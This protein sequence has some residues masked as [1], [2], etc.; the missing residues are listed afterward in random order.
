MPGA[1][2]WSVEDEEPSF[3]LP[4]TRIFF[5]AATVKDEDSES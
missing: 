5:D 2:N 4:G 3:S 1:S